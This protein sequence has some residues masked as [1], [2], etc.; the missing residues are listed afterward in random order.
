MVIK[1]NTQKILALA[2]GTLISFPAL[3]YAVANI[4]ELVSI[5]VLSSIAL[6]M[7]YAGAYAVVIVA[8]LLTMKKTTWLRSP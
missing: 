7:L 2:L 5:P 4:A 6:P 3:T 8:M 1:K